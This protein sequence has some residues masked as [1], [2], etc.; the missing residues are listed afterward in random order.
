MGEVFPDLLGHQQTVDDGAPSGPALK[1]LHLADDW[2]AEL[3]LAGPGRRDPEFVE[4]LLTTGPV[5]SRSCTAGCSDG[6]GQQH[7]QRT[8]REFAFASLD[9]LG[10]V[11]PGVAA[12]GTITREPG[13]LQTQ[14]WMATEGKTLART[15]EPVLPEPARGPR[16]RDLQAQTTGAFLTQATG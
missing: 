14:V 4:W 15:V 16:G 2:P 9:L 6:H 12:L 3:I 5:V 10:G 1:K 7:C 13:V 8:D 11:E